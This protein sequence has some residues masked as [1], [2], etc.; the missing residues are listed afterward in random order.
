MDVSAFQAWLIPAVRQQRSLDRVQSIWE[1]PPSE[2]LPDKNLVLLSFTVCC[3][4]V[5]Y[6]TAD[7]SNVGIWVE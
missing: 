3:T 6:I 1:D 5:F 2:K 4:I 7:S